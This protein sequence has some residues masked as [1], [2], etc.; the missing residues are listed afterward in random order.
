LVTCLPV[1]SSQWHQ[2]S[3]VNSSSTYPVTHWSCGASDFDI[4][5]G[6]SPRHVMVVTKEDI[7]FKCP[8]QRRAK[9]SEKTTTTISW[10]DV[11]AKGLVQ[12]HAS[13]EDMEV[14][15]GTA[16]RAVLQPQPAEDHSNAPQRGDNAWQGRGATKRQRSCR[17]LRSTRK[18]PQRDTH[19]HV[20]IAGSR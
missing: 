16:E 11:A 6:G 19:Y 4:V 2:N 9:D 18:T 1:P 20:T 13:T 3:D 15:T 8:H 5:R 17:S 12:P 7:C 10:A 14:G